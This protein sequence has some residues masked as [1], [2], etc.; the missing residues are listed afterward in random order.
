[1]KTEFE[2]IKEHKK[3]TYRCEV[4]NTGYTSETDAINC[5]RRCSVRSSCKHEFEYE[6]WFYREE[7]YVEIVKKCK[8][9][10]LSESETIDPD[11]FS[12]ETSK[13]LYEEYCK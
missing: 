2:I 3:Y 10:N 5:E 12:P 13:M 7:R 11:D 9:C 1:M 8:K 6:T 4:C